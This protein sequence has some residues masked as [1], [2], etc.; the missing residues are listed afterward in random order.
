M[1]LLVTAP[2]CGLLLNRHV[3][4]KKVGKPKNF[5]EKREKNA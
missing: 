4:A 1:G 5:F 3:K 2:V